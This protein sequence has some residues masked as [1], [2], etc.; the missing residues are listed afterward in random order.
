MNPAKQVEKHFSHLGANISQFPKFPGS[1]VSKFSSVQVLQFSSFQ[2]SPG[3]RFFGLQL[4]KLS[5]SQVFKLFSFL[6]VELPGF[7][8][9]KPRVFTIITVA[10][11]PGWYFVD[12]VFKM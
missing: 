7:R 9:V 11:D 6:V 8:V 4:C 5:S 1:Q 2:I 10:G 12:S 3:F